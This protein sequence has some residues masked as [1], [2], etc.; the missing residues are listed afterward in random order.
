MELDAAFWVALLTGLAAL[1]QA[2]SGFGFSLLVVPPLSLVIGARQA[3]VVANLLSV[4][5]GLLIVGQLRRSVDWRLFRWLFAGSVAGMP[6][7]LAVILAVDQTVLKAMIAVVVLV[8]TVALWR[9]LRFAK[10][11]RRGDLAAGFISGVLNTSTS[12]SGPP[13]VVYLQGQETAPANFRATLAA[14][15]LASSTIAV[16]LLAAGGEVRGS[17]LAYAGLGLVA[18]FPAWAIGSRLGRKVEPRRFRALVMA[19]LVVSAAVALAT[20]AV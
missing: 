2:L 18:V 8:S 20:V 11:S 16:G 10:A 13:V 3:V 15:F 4:A 12:M 6:L 17:S 19:V 1:C 7:G 5:L 9:G 14:Y